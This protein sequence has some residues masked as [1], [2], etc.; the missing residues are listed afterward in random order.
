MI[1]KNMWLVIGGAIL[2]FATSFW[3]A[4]VYEGEYNGSIPLG[5]ILIMLRLVDIVAC[6]MLRHGFFNFR[7]VRVYYRGAMIACGVCIC[8]G[9]LGLVGL[10]DLSKLMI[11]H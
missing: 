9:L 11:R 2:T 3:Q 1:I 8:L 10:I 6:T 7:V 5:L 4:G